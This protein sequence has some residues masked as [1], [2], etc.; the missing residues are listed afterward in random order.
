MRAQPERMAPGIKLLGP[1]AVEPRG[2][3]GHPC[4]R[5]NP[6]RPS[7][8]LALSR[9]SRAT[10]ATKFGFMRRSVWVRL[11]LLVAL[12]VV[13]FGVT[14]R[15]DEPAA[16]GTSKRIGAVVTSLAATSL[17]TEAAGL[18]SNPH[19]PFNRFVDGRP[20]KHRWLT[21][22]AVLPAVVLLAAMARRLN[23]H[24]AAAATAGWGRWSLGPPCGPP[25][26]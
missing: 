9:I 24:P 19:R 17:E 12:G 23:G 3:F 22:M 25:S 16:A 1:S 13:F 8:E 15:P 21:L 4:H 14:L 10:T 20:L 11:G 2:T 7:H 18:R 6:R 5:R 26:L